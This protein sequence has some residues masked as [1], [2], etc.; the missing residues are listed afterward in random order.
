MLVAGFREGIGGI[1]LLGIV[2]LLGNFWVISGIVF[3]AVLFVEFWKLLKLVLNFVNWFLLLL[4]GGGGGG[5]DGGLLEGRG[6]GGFK[7]GFFEGKGGGVFRGGLFEGRGG[8]DSDGGGGGDLVGGFILEGILGGDLEGGF[9]CEYCFGVELNDGILGGLKEGLG[10]ELDLF[11]E[12]FWLLFYWFGLLCEEVLEV[13]FWLLNICR[14][15]IG[16]GGFVIFSG[17]VIG[18]W[19]R[20]WLGIFEVLNGSFFFIC[21]VFDDK[22][23]FIRFWLVFLGIDFICLF[24]IV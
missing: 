16:G 12:W 1:G 3:L 24:I 11:F 2:L 13:R 21:L 14:E 17:G 9:W 10:G 6:G 18:F 23:V 5:F 15:G 4:V 20:N 22:G 8:G 19:L 7:G